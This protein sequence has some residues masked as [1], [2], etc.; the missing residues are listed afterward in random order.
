MA[1]VARLAKLA[2]DRFGEDIINSAG[3]DIDNGYAYMRLN[4]SDGTSPRLIT[5]ID[6]IERGLDIDK[7]IETFFAVNGILRDANKTRPAAIS[8]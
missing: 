3:I 1:F 4:L 6:R 8:K 7:E 2:T 5:S